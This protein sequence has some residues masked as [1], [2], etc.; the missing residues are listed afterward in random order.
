MVWVEFSYLSDK[1][2]RVVWT[3]DSAWQYMRLHHKHCPERQ[4]YS[5]RSSNLRFVQSIWNVQ[6]LKHGSGRVS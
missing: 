1:S 5:N 6:M 4:I 3:V 2:F